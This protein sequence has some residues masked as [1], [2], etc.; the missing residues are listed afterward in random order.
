MP[1]VSDWWHNRSDD[2][3]KDRAGDTDP[4]RRN[5]DTVYRPNQAD[6]FWTK[7]VWDILNFCVGVLPIVPLVRDFQSDTPVGTL[8]WILDGVGAVLP[9][10]PYAGIPGD[11]IKA[12]VMAAKEGASA[13]EVMSAIGRG[14]AHGSLAMDMV[15]D[16]AKNGAAAVEKMVPTL[17]RVAGRGLKWVVQLAHMVYKLVVKLRNK[18]QKL[19]KMSSMASK[20]PQEL[21]LG[22]LK[23]VKTG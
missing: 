17:N 9:F 16:A 5:A 20:G 12:G 14:I 18:A 4:L 13:A 22:L 21:R 1:T 2:Q 19:V 7:H 10:I 23:L 11:A 6:D 15:A 8:N 3:I